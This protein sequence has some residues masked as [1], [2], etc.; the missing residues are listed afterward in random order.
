[1][2]MTPAAITL[3]GNGFDLP[4]LLG[5]PSYEYGGPNTHATSLY[6]LVTA[7]VIAVM[8]GYGSAL[9]VLHLLS[10][11]AGA[12]LAAAVFVIAHRITAS[13][14]TSALAAL[15]TMLYPP[16]LVQAS[17]VYLDLPLAAAM[18]WSI[19]LGVRHRYGLAILAATLAAWIKPTGIIVVPVLAYILHRGTL[20]NRTRRT[21]T[22]L[23]VLP[24]AVALMPLLTATPRRTRSEFSAFERTILTALDTA[25][26]SSHVPA[27]ILLLGSTAIALLIRR[28]RG[29]RAENIGNGDAFTAV[30]IGLLATVAFYLLNPLVTSGFE[31]LPR[32]TVTLAPLLAILV[33]AGIHRAPPILRTSI[34]LGISGALLV[35]A[36][37]WLT[38]N[39]G[40]NYAISER[41]LR[42]EDHL[43]VQMEAIGDLE[44]LGPT[45]P[46]FYDH[47]TYYRFKYPEMGWVDA[48]S[49]NGTAVYLASPGTYT[50]DSMP[51]EFA[52]LL[53]RQWLGG[54]T[55]RALWR[56][57][58]ASSRH[59]IEVHLHEVGEFQNYVVVIQEVDALSN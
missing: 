8:G 51:Q 54:D 56:E 13:A 16:V 9:P 14:Y 12:A 39:A 47:F 22:G 50:L 43:A 57:A 40:N 10:F 21:F 25:W 44:Q 35:M 11:V 32:Y 15:I 17:D 7:V 31:L 26:Y 29:P 53:E 5:Q 49:P 3:A 42:Y 30:L 46:V 18:M 48:D 33:T 6:T 38:P 27:L 2:G 55:L 1:M 36:F 19:A 59:A 23:L 41:D 4:A 58:H 24:L 52:M 28:G 20:P 34:G 37:G 45:L